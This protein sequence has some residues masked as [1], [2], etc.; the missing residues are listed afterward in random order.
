MPLFPVNDDLITIGNQSWNIP[1]MPPSWSCTPY[2]QITVMGA[3]IHSAKEEP[4]T[5]GN[6]SWNRPLIPPS[7]SCTP[8]L[9]TVM[10]AKI[11]SAKEE[12]D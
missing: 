7:W 6:Q 1:L 10:D 2:T 4:I 12:P 5:T 11:H 8:Y 3:K 9:I